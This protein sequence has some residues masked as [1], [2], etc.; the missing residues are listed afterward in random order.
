[1]EPVLGK[2]HNGNVCQMCVVV[3]N[4][5][6]EKEEGISLTTLFDER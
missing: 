2:M 6:N 1:M 3:I 5:V 4:S